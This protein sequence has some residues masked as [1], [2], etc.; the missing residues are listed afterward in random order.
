MDYLGAIGDT[1]NT[2]GTEQGNW[3]SEL[4]G[5]KEQLPKISPSEL[6]SPFVGPP[7][8][9]LNFGPYGQVTQTPVSAKAQSEQPTSSAAQG[10]WDSPLGW[11]LQA[12]NPKNLSGL[13]SVP[14]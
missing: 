3:I 8:Y 7:Q 12:I 1:L 2:V 13:T 4:L 11:L 10:F 6:H 9:Q 5:Y 14:Y